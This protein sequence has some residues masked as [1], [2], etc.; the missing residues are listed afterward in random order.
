M[1]QTLLT[2]HFATGQAWWTAPWT[3][4]ESHR[5][6]E[7]QS[8]G[9]R[10]W[11]QL[12]RCRGSTAF[13]TLNFLGSIRSGFRHQ[14]HSFVIAKDHRERLEVPCRLQ[15]RLWMSTSCGWGCIS[16]KRNAGGRGCRW[17]AGQVAGRRTH[18]G[19][20]PPWG[21]QSWGRSQGV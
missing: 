10:F 7:D 6:H 8:Q 17:P 18:V 3:A 13:R 4:R 9:S 11:W 14:V 12:K 2:R 19:I 5:P 16:S 20:S 21:R 15:P 1:V